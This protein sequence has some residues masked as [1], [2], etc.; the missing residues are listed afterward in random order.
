MNNNKQAKKTLKNLFKV[1]LRQG[2]FS[3]YN[4]QKFIYK[5][6]TTTRTPNVRPKLNLQEIHKQ[7]R[8]E[9]RSSALSGSTFDP[10]DWQLIR[11]HRLDQLT[12]VLRKS[13]TVT[14]RAVV[15]NAQ[16]KQQQKKPGFCVIFPWVCK[17]LCVTGLTW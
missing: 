16:R 3:R 5:N 4:G 1:K 11:C 8:F 6:S 15:L 10:R 13:K 14:N 9:D 7:Q 17:S 12:Q 2:A